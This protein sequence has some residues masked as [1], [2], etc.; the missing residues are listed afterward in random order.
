[1]SFDRI[2]ATYVFCMNY[3]SG[4][5]SRLYRILSK[6]S[7][8]YQVRLSDRAIDAIQGDK[9]IQEWSYANSIYNHLVEKFRYGMEY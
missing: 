3:H 5:G 4:Q 7:T 2:A 1:M 8:H 9:I 6:L